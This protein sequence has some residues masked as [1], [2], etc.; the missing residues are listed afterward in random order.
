[1]KIEKD[2]PIP[3]SLAQVIQEMKSGESVVISENDRM[4]AINGARYHK[5]KIRTKK[6]REGKIRIWRV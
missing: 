2:I 6:E 4:K 3:K 5:I 1:M